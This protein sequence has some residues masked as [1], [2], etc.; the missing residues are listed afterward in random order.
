MT[1]VAN[2][3]GNYLLDSGMRAQEFEFLGQ[4]LARV[5]LRRIYSHGD[6]ADLPRLC[7]AICNDVQELTSIGVSP[8]QR[9]LGERFLND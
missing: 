9:I 4:V 5:P 1:L 7:D 2:T 3:F 8:R 6:L